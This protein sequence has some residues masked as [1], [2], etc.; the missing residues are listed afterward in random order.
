M[1]GVFTFDFILKKYVSDEIAGV[2]LNISLVIFHSFQV[3]INILKSKSW[4]LYFIMRRWAPSSKG[5][6]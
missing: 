1:S 6:L 3:K 4:C 5:Q 2:L